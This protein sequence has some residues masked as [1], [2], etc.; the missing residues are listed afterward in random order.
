MRHR[1]VPAATLQADLETIGGSHNRTGP[2]RGGSG[3]QVRPVVQGIDLIGGKPF[4]QAVC[5]HLPRA[6][7]AFLGGLEDE[8]HRPVKAS[9]P[10]QMLRGPQQHGDMS[11]MS[12]SVE[13]ARRLARIGQ[14][15]VFVDRQGVHVG[16]EAQASIGAPGAQNADDP[17][18][19]DAGDHFEPDVAQ[20]PGDER[21]RPVLRETEFGMGVD[22]PPQGDQGRHEIVNHHPAANHRLNS[23]AE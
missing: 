11:V 6:A 3:R 9:C 15:A 20:G 4:E 1:R 14:S 13:N 2:R 12:A 8:V 17:C 19:A 23:L 22:V 7:E 10:R 18:A 5:N 21:R 16:A